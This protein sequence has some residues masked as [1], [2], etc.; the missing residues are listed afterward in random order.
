MILSNEMKYKKQIHC[1]L[2]SNG[3][4]V[5]SSLKYTEEF[6]NVFFVILSYLADQFVG[7]IL[8]LYLGGTRFESESSYGLS[9]Q[10]IFFFFLVFSSVS[11]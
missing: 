1:S 11:R 3:E 9:C 7:N 2:H 5:Y 8:G 4:N 10:G 6:R